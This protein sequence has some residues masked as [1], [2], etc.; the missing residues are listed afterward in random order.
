MSG[1]E[2]VLL[3]S[4]RAA[5]A[6]ALPFAAA[7]DACVAQATTGKGEERHG[8]GLRFCEQPWVTLACRHGVGFLTG[9]AEKKWHEAETSVIATD[10]ARY[11]REVVGAINYALMALIWVGVLD[12]G[13]RPVPPSMVEMS[14]GR[15]LEAAWPVVQ[16]RTRPRTLVWPYLT[17]GR[18]DLVVALQNAVLHMAAAVC[19]RMERARRVGGVA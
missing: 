16:P 15:W 13:R 10:D 11:V 17:M 4:Q 8:H 5:R 14:P 3:P 9:Q 7:L 1:R 12:E 19:G 6:V 18:A 2:G